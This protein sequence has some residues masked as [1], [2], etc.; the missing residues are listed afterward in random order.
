M[1]LDKASLSQDDTQKALHARMHAG[2]GAVFLFS[3]FD[4]KLFVQSKCS[5]HGT[6]IN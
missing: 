6:S 1:S 2:N 3:C 4:F 5:V